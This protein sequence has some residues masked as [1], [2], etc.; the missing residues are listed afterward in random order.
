MARFVPLYKKKSKTNVENYI[1]I[2]LLS[3]IS[4]VFEKVVFSQLKCFLTE[5]KLLYKFQSRFRSSYST[6]TCLIHL[7]DYIKH[8]CDISN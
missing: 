2:Y 3:I 4:I 5:H 7:T 6:D 8:D 1:Q